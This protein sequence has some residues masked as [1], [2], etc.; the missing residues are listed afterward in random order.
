MRVEKSVERE[1]P[2][3]AVASAVARQHVWRFCSGLPRDVVEV[4]A[5]LTSELVTNAVRHAK[6]SI[7]LRMRRE[8]TAL[9]V[10]VDDDSAEPP[11]AMNVDATAIGGRG[12]IL[13]DRLA[14]AWGVVTRHGGKAVWFR[15][16]TH[17]Q[18]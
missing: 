11:V 10:E 3:S 5:L 13:V 16:P 2:R 8:P 12:V 9:H 18:S 4:A 14:A 7:R 1:L 15:L 17:Q 6:G